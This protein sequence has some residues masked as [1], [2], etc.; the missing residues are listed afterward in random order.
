MLRTPAGNINIRVTKN[1]T[2]LNVSLLYLPIF[3]LALIC[4][5]LYV[6][7]AFSVRNYVLFQ[8]DAFYYIN[9]NLAAYP[10]TEC[11]LTQLGDA[12]VL[13]SFLCI[14]MLYAPKI[15]ESFVAA[16]MVSLVFSSTLKNFFAIPRPSVALDNSCFSILGT[17]ARGY[18]SLPSGHS[19]TIFT[20]LTVLFFGLMPTKLRY[21]ILWG[22]FILTFGLLVSSSRVAVGAHYP[23]DVLIGSILGY[24][25]GLLG[26]FISVRKNYMVWISGLKF[27]KIFNILI[28]ICCVSLILKIIKENYIIYYLAL[29]SLIFSLYKLFY[30]QIKK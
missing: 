28:V 10:K 3:F 13:L 7:D 19:I 2:R 23:L 27:Q 26:I 21:R 8:T 1:L 16:S 20:T 25:A 5:V 11:N 18:T 6:N 4:F 15:W 12:S 9:H 30:V 22:I 29:F 17:T 24:I 14:L